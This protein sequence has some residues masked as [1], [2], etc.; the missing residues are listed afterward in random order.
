M[1]YNPLVLMIV[2]IFFIALVVFFVLV[3]I[4][5]IALAFVE[6]GIPPQYIFMTLMAILLG[7]FINI[8]VRRIP[9]SS[10]NRRTTAHYFGISYSTPIWRPRYT[11]LAVNLGGAIIPIIICLYLFFK[12]SLRM[13]A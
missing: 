9:Q 6:I 1:I 3:Q 8:P 4:N 2:G 12:T 7:S 13:M 10:I 11:L 5:V